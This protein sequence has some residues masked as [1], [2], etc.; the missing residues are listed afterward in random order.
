MEQTSQGWRSDVGVTQEQEA[1]LS[2]S[3]QDPSVTPYWQRLAWNQV[4]E[5]RCGFW[6]PLL[7]IPNRVQRGSVWNQGHGLVSSPGP[8]GCS[9]HAHTGLR[10]TAPA[11]RVL[12]GPRLRLTLGAPFIPP[13]AYGRPYRMGL[14]EQPWFAAL[15]HSSQVLPSIWWAN[16]KQ[17]TNLTV[18]EISIWEELFWAQLRP[19]EWVEVGIKVG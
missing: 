11:S 18:D 5:Q 2:S 1:P 3:W 4:V 15:W 10:S 8:S 19:N 14:L 13:A 9:C 7:S 6:N 17:D 16:M 12:L